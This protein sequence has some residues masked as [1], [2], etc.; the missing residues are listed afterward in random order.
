[1]YSQSLIENVRESNDIVDLINTYVRLQQ[2]GG[3]Y[4]GLCPFH[5]EK[6]PS[7]SVSAD[8][9]L[10]HCFGCG[11]SGNI[12]TFLMEMD[13][14]DFIEALEKLA[15]RANIQLEQS[16]NAEDYRK[17]KEQ[18]DIQYELMRD[19][20]RFFYDNLENDSKKFASN[21]LDNRG[22][23][24]KIRKQFGL[25]FASNK[26]QLYE[27][28]KE[29]GYSNEDVVLSGLVVDKNGKYYDKF[30]DR[31]MFPIFE[32]NGKIV[33]FG[34]RVFD[35]SLPKYLNSPETIIFNKSKILYGLN[36]AKL[37]KNTEYVLVEGYMD[38]IAL[39]EAGFTNAVGVLGTAFNENH[40]RTLRKF[41]D[42]VTLLFDS[43]EAGLK[44][45]KRSIDVLVEAGF[46]VNVL[47]LKGAKDP[48]EYIKKF[49]NEAFANELNN[50][51]SHIT[52]SII[53]L[54]NSYDFDNPSDVLSFTKKAVELLKI[55]ENNIERN[56]YIKEIVKI[57]G[58]REDILQKE[59]E[60]DSVVT[61][62]INIIKSQSNIN[63]G[64]MPKAV[65]LALNNLI[66]N[67]T[68]DIELAKKLEGNLKPEYIVDETYGK[69]LS[70][71]YEL[72]NENVK[73]TPVLLMD[74]FYNKDEQKII[75]SIYSTYNEYEDD[76]ELN[77]ILTDQCKA[78]LNYYIDNK[79]TSITEMADVIEFA[80]IKKN[81]MNF[82]L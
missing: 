71:I 50:S 44:A 43:D 55:I 5:N 59:V 72:H 19:S 3:S 22:V 49:G 45:T 34:G 60:K 69:I 25:G 14:L 58:L 39:H 15:D 23:S 81:L 54:K 76:I 48:D 62:K 28:L 64:N 30:Y 6:S 51:V 1:M 24:K 20:A 8:K 41:T 57:T 70:K 73:I 77:K 66:N 35:D 21:Y 38:V 16:T 26:N 80:K 74:Y 68:D 78:V 65:K 40:V 11:A 33:G 7:F 27:F 75:S 63:E 31:L 36:R 10:Y 67:L 32:H 56:V 52:F 79:S 61:T 29:K 2:K 9:Q 18:R 42:T 53:Q 82:V 4:V 12:Y 13:N 17:T 37:T 47:T 46:K